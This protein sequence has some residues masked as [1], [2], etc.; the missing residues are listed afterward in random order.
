MDTDFKV[1]T[2]NHI[3]TGPIMNSSLT[4]MGLSRS[5]LLS[6]LCDVV[7]SRGRLKAEF[8]EKIKDLSSG[9]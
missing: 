3:G 6:L 8:R 5:D 9:N 4:R 7:F 1:W 2:G